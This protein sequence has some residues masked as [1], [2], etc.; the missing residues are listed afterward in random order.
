MKTKNI[1][2]I[3]VLTTAILLGFQARA[4]E[5]VIEERSETY[6]CEVKTTDGKDYINLDIAQSKCEQEIKNEE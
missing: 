5:N 6:N 1:F 2:N 4:S 3:V